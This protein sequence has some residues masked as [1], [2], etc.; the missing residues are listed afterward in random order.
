M[1]VLGWTP[2]ISAAALGVVTA[3]KCSKNLFGLLGERRLFLV[4]MIR[5][6]DCF[7][8]LSYLS[9]FYYPISTP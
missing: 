6:I 2:I 8:G 5:I 9:R 4:Y 1:T 3:T 7:H